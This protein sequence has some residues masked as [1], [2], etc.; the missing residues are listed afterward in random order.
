MSAR[1]F[2]SLLQLEIHKKVASAFLWGVLRTELQN[3][4][5]R[6]C[7]MRQYD[8]VGPAGINAMVDAK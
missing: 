4:A 6:S 2:Y 1:C 3:N 5:P 7:R 8:F